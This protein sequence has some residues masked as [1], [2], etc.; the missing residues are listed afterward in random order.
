[1]LQG[2]A[3]FGRVLS[4]FMATLSS[5]PVHKQRILKREPTVDPQAFRA[6]CDDVISYLGVAPADYEDGNLLFKLS[7]AHD[8]HFT[9]LCGNR[10]Q[11]LSGHLY[12]GCLGFHGLGS[13]YAFHGV[14]NNLQSYSDGTC[15]SKASL[16]QA[17]VCDPWLDARQ[18]ANEFLNGQR[19][20]RGEPLICISG[21]SPSLAP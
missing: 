1:M 4:W 18:S 8:K 6:Q 14:E 17:F 7:K 10:L 11:R 5:L 3:A 21:P 13:T 2:V 20:A 12:W 15:T 16:T 9:E 19:R